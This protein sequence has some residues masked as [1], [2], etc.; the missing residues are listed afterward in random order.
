[1]PISA[2]LRFGAWPWIKRISTAGLRAPGHF[3]AA[4]LATS[5][6]G[7]EALVAA[8]AQ[9][10]S[11]LNRHH[12]DALA[13]FAAALAGKPDGPWR[14]T[15]IDP[16]GI[17]L[18]CDDRTARIAFPG[19]F[20]PYKISARYCLNSSR[21]RGEPRATGHRMTLE[22]ARRKLGCFLLSS[23]AARR[24]VL[25]LE[26]RGRAVKTS[27]ITINQA[28]PFNPAFGA[29]GFGLKDQASKLGGQA[30]RCRLRGKCG[31]KTSKRESKWTLM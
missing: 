8:E 3:K 18:G 22:A 11:E 2:T 25:N 5:L 13:Q 27:G 17:D 29:E 28:G 7:A 4:A 21:P 30:L 14:A 9:A 1:M 12:R 24:R 23:R 26:F 31:H 6:D 10:L 19:R 15:G 20:V 16:E